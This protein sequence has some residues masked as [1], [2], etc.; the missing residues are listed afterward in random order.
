MSLA[1]LVITSVTV[2]GRSKSEVARDFKI[3]RYWVQ[4][5]VKRYEAEGEA[6]FAPRS[7]RPHTN[8]GAISAELE[9][10]IV[11]LRKDLS[12]KGLDAGAETIRAHLAAAGVARLPAVSTIWRVLT[13]RGFVTPQPRKRP[14]GA[15]KRFCADLPNERWQADITHWQL[16]DGTGVEIHNIIDDHSRLAV[17]S[18]ARATTTAPDVVADFRAAFGRYGIPRSVLT[19]NGAVYTGTPRRGG[20]VA[21][22]IELDLLGVGLHHSRPY[23]PQTQGKVER[24]HQTMKKWLAAQPPA[25]TIPT[26]QHQLNRFSRYYNTI[27]PHRAI[28]RRTPAQAYTARTKASPAKPSIA[29][30]YRVRRD[31]VDTGGVI[32]LRYHSQL[33]HIGLGREHARKPVLA[34]IADRYIRVVHADTGELLRELTLDPN[35]DYQPLGRPPGPRP[36]T[37]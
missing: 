35:R 22:E 27:R 36:K 26:L 21:L 6:A 10:Q 30:H 32:T 28:D 14:R 4:Q 31:K 12:R 3:S 13:R 9:D 29:A 1:E 18:K 34:L 25:P 37:P 19:D 2:E 17:G 33:R 20:R 11:G 8:P 16:A 23:H 5:L 24:F 15:W 7:R